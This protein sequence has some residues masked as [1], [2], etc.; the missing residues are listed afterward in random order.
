[1][2]IVTR[3]LEANSSIH[4]SNTNNI[5]SKTVGFSSTLGIGYLVLGT[6][7]VVVLLTLVFLY[8]SVF[9][10]RKKRY[11]NIAV[12]KSDDDDDD[13]DDDDE[14]NDDGDEAH[15]MHRRRVSTK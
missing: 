8:R 3:T 1:L 7:V 12:Q 4:Q 5:N 9:R 15:T 2:T 10:P 13:D 14:D 11:M 6:G